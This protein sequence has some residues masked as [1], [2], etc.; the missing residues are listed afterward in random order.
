MPNIA[1]QLI[2]QFAW[3]I[4]ILALVF[5]AI[6]IWIFIRTM[7]MMFLWH[8]DAEAHLHFWKDLR[9]LLLWL[10]LAFV[11]GFLPHLCA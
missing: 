5:L 6:A 7:H 11:V 1:C 10:A 3:A 8:G 2:T 4:Q 9:W